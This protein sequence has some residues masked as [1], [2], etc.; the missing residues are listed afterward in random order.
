[1]AFGWL[2]YG[3]VGRGIKIKLATREDESSSLSQKLV[4]LTQ[5]SM[6]TNS[7][8]SPLLPYHLN[9]QIIDEQNE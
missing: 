6:N 7:Y 5:P 9:S 3:N 1:M 4:C 8:S 2:E